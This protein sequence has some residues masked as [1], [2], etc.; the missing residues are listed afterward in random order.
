MSLTN[1]PI[2]LVIFQS[3]FTEFHYQLLEIN[4]YKPEFEIVVLDL[5]ILLSP[6]SQKLKKVRHKEI[7]EL[8]APKKWIDLLIILYKLR[9]KFSSQLKSQ[10]ISIYGA[11]VFSINS[12]IFHILFLLYFKKN[13]FAI[14]RLWNGG[15]LVKK[16]VALK[17]QIN[18]YSNLA[19][20]QTQK[21]TKINDLCCK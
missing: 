19:L 8:I 3:R 16:T 1:K 2:M 5:S 12:L 20:L 7:S 21:C 18:F 14:I 11:T 15:I 17:N 10:S 13:F 4:H 6:F 9:Q